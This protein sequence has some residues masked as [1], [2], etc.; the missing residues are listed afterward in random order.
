MAKLRLWWGLCY[1]NAMGVCS[2]VLVAL[3]STLSALAADCGTTGAAVGT[4]FIARGIGAITGR[5]G[6]RG[7]PRRRGA[8][9]R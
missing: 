7:S 3:G 8:G 4:V 9:T 1:A 6:P 2:I 5:S